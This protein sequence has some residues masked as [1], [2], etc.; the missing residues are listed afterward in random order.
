MPFE[1]FANLTTNIYLTKKGVMLSK[2]NTLTL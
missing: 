1:F 2:H